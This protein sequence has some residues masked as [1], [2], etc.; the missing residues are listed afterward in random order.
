MS[1][2]NVCPKCGSQDVILI[3]YGYPT[4]E[5]GEAAERG[6]LALG[7]CCVGDNDPDRTCKACGHN[8]RACGDAAG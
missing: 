3:V 4:V 5:A 2:K 6:E 8:W 1:R 7:G